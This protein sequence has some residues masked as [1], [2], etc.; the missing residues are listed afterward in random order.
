MCVC[1]CASSGRFSGFYTE[2]KNTNGGLSLGMEDFSIDGNQQTCVDKYTCT[3]L[4]LD[5]YTEVTLF[6]MAQSKHLSFKKQL[7]GKCLVKK[8]MHF[9]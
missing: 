7:A 1:V 8:K 3:C 2:N 6:S 4:Y 5:N 9:I